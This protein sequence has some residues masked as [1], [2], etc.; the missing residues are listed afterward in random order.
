VCGRDPKGFKENA[1]AMNSWRVTL[2]TR[3][4]KSLKYFVLLFWYFRT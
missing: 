3:E 1:A 2:K 4:L